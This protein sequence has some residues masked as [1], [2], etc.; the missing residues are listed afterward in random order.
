MNDAEIQKE[1][2]YDQL[3]AQHANQQARISHMQ[4][5]VDRNRA[6]ASKAKQAQSRIKALEKL[7]ELAAVQSQSSFQ[8]EFS[9]IINCPNPLLNLENIEFAYVGATNKIIFKKLNFYVRPGARIALLGLNGEGKSTLM[10]LLSATVVAQKGTRHAG[11]GLKIGYFAQEQAEEFPIDETPLSWFTEISMNNN[12]KE[13][14]GY[15]G[16]FAFS[17]ER[18]VQKIAT[19]SGGEKARLALAWI[20]WQKPQ[21][22]LLDEPTNHLDLEMREALSF[23]LQSFS[24]AVV[25]VSH[26]RQL[27]MNTVDELWWV[28]NG[29]A[30]PFVGDLEDYEQ[31]L[32]KAR[33]LLA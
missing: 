4:E 10:K 26:D 33:K 9:E 11:P 2:R 21:L 30:E 3:V 5:F 18:A 22:L 23:A 16:R 15:L 8:F 14:R 13:I 27:I 20:V 25:L 24:G 7:P 6:K 29:V 28:H 32:K 19:L 17:D 1:A 12:H 31:K